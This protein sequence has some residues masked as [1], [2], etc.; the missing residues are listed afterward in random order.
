M[1]KIYRT[2]P[3]YLLLFI[4][5]ALL[6]IGMLMIFSASPT[7]AMKKLG[8]SY[9]FLHRHIIALLIGSIALYYG[10]R[11]DHFQLRN[12]ANYIIAAA[13]ILLVMVLIP[14]IGGR[15]LG[16]QRW[17]LF[18]GL[19]SFQPA[20]LAKLALIIYLA[21]E[22]S[23]KTLNSAVLPALGI[24]AALALLIIKEPDLGTMIVITAIAFSMF[25]I[26][27]ANIRYIYSML[28]AAGLA[29]IA[30]SITHQARMNRLLAFLDPW[31]YSE[32][33]GY[34]IKQSFIAIGTGGLFGMGLGKSMQ[35]LFWLPSNYN[36]FIYAV[37]CEETG[38]IGAIIV[39][40]LFLAFI[41]RGVRIVRNCP[42]MF[43]LLLSGGIVS[44]IGFQALL[45]MC[46]VLGLLPTTGIPLP[47]IS[48]GGTSIVVS[49]FGV[50]LLLNISQ[51][52]SAA[53][54][55]GGAK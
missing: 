42:D 51:F 29:I 33:I 8:D 45:N 40:L 13:I 54:T 18:F 24:T 23:A 37:L 26:A 55:A 34:N 27:G 48:Y 19:F 39:V 2:R 9:Y 31:K 36:D 38:F 35:K 32:T 50:G 30:I 1:S 44:W 43:S 53:A 25:Y 11:M 17:I 5:V 52:R 10:M 16:G 7:M 14:G 12:W 3:D 28:L 47:F 6:S 4:V 22:L 46:V 15:Y 21:K 41:G 20:E 49:L